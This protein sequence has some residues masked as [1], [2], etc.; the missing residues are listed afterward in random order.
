MDIEFDAERMVEA[1][2][3]VEGSILLDEADSELGKS[4]DGFMEVDGI[5]DETVVTDESGWDIKYDFG[6]DLAYSFCGP[7]GLKS[8]YR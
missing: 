3:I 2:E 7:N 5:G 8:I 4:V 1:V 6:K